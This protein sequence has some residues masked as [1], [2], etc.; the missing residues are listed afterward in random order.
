[1]F[2]SFSGNSRRPRQ[3]NLS[4]QHI[5]PFA[6]SGW[7]G[8]SASGARKTIAAAQQERQHRQLE[9]DRLQASKRIQRTW[10]GHRTR[11]ELAEVRRQEW[12]QLNR[13]VSQ[14]SQT[15]T[16]VDQ[17]LALFLSFFSSRNNDDILR[18]QQV[19]ERVQSAKDTGYLG[20]MASRHKLSRLARIILGTVESRM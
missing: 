18:L 14:Q 20:T 12:E 2:Q 15:W 8:P 9:R 10:R 4:G 16:T 11:R 3:V 13:N 1:M 5:D 19:S 17:E 7:G 6:A